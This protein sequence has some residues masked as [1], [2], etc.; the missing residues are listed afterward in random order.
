MLS[1]RAHA[2]LVINF[3]PILIRNILPNATT[4]YAYDQKYPNV[5]PAVESHCVFRPL[6]PAVFLHLHFYSSEML[7][8]VARPSPVFSSCLHRTWPRAHLGN[9]LLGLFA[10][11]GSKLPGL[12]HSLS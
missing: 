4:R 5:I 6:Q 3:I 9:S 8:P 11:A 10:V 12:L 1:H 2:L 7:P